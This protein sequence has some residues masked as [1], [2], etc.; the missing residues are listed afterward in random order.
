MITREAIASDL[1]RLTYYLAARS[2]KCS[3]CP[4]QN[5]A[6]CRTTGGGNAALVTTHKARWDRIAHWSEQQL[7]TAH[8]MVKQEGRSAFWSRMP[9]GFYAEQEAAAAPI[10]AKAKAATP[11]GVRLSESQAERIERAAAK[12]GVYHVSTAHFHGDAVDRQ[13][14]NAL[15]EKGILRF[16]ELADHG[17][18]R[19]MELTEFG[20][21][22]YHQHRL[23]IRRVP[24]ELHPPICPCRPRD[25]FEQVEQAN[26]IPEAQEPQRR[27]R[28]VWEQVKPEPQ[29]RLVSERRKPLSPVRGVADLDAYRARRSAAPAGDIA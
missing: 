4:A 21:N 13:S 18:E 7:S 9:D 5:G 27:L 29:L 8:D 28:Q 11:K 22:V 26:A 12:A 3:K 23:I 10:V 14:V 17:Y 6:E 19:R 20:W 16:V 25:A 1:L 15:E 2:V 24:D